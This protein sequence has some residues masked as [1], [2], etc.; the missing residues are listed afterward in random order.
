[1]SINMND[2]NGSLIIGDHGTIDNSINITNHFN[3]RYNLKERFDAG[4]EEYEYSAYCVGQFGEKAFKGCVPVTFTNLHSQNKFMYDHLHIDVPKEWYS[5]LY[6][7]GH[8]MKFKATVH[9]YNRSNKSKDYTLTITEIYTEDSS[10]QTD[11]KFV[12]SL[13]YPSFNISEENFNDGKYIIEEDYSQETIAE[14]T[15]RLLTMLDSSLAS[16]DQSFYSGFITNFILTQYFLNT[17]LNEQCNQL[18]VIRQLDKDVLIDLALIVSDVIMKFN[19]GT[20]SLYKY[21]DIFSHITYICN[22]IQNIDK[23]V[24]LKCKKNDNLY[25]EVSNNLETFGNKIGHNETK[26]MF[27]KLKKRHFDFG[28]KYPEN[29]EELEKEKAKLW[30]SLLTMFHNLG[31]VNI[32]A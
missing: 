8:I 4:N 2:N 25:N 22:I 19:N 5:K 26:K 16:I 18:Y 6:F 1:M 3:Q 30:N 11:I 32:L 28:F 24:N 21:K 10:K 29:E 20:E 27:D 13:K 17:S 31:Y 23:N 15:I 9:D 14:F 7:D 12:N